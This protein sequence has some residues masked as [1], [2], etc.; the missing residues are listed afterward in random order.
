MPV[1]NQP[2]FLQ[3]LIS[4]SLGTTKLWKHQ[5]SIHTNGWCVMF[6]FIYIPSFCLRFL[7]SSFLLSVTSS[8]TFASGHYIAS[9]YITCL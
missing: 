1:V 4:V 3:N 7:S 8:Y 5:T 9:L 2:F 6:Y